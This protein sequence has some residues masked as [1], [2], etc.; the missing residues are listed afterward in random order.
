[1]D[2]FHFLSGTSPDLLLVSLESDRLRLEPIS[3]SYAQDIF[4][5]FTSEITRY[6][7]PK[8]ATKIEETLEFIRESRQSMTY[9]NNLQLVVLDK[10]TKE[11]IGCCGLHG[12]PNIRIPELG[13]WLKKSAHGRGYG[14]EAV[15]CLVAWASKQLDVDGFIYPV[16]K[17]NLASCKIPESLGGVII[18][19]FQDMGLAGNVLDEVVYKISL[20][21]G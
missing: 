9:G 18:D 15:R 12:E 13:I 3:E 6:M 14:R 17:R 20:E 7:F 11:F 4:R 19:A 1:M 16:D 2:T 8:P 10:E 5:E 21:K